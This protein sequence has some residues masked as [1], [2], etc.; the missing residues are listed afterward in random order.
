MS[1][2]KRSLD[3]T[4]A[5]LALIVLS[6]LLLIAAIGIKLTSPGPILYRA[7]RIAR[8]RRWSADRRAKVRWSVRSFSRL[9]SFCPLCFLFAF[10][11][12]VVYFSEAVVAT[13][14]CPI[15]F[16][17]TF[18]DDSQC[19]VDTGKNASGFEFAAFARRVA[20]RPLPE[21]LQA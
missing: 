17:T 1:F 2:L 7:P 20:C 6:P 12:S 18:E 10:P 5:F 19:F 11:L 14:L 15:E 16:P 13:S 9:V 8:D 3:A 21:L 4:V